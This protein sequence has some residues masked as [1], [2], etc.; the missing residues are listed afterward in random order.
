[1]TRRAGLTLREFFALGFGTM[2]GSGWLTVLGYWL[3]TAGPVGAVIAF[4]ASC[5]FVMMVALAYAELGAAYPITG[6]EVAYS[7]VAFGSPAAFTVGWM[8]VLIFIGYVCFLLV[9]VGWVFGV[10]FPGLRGPI[11]YQAFEESIYLGEMLFGLCIA[12]YLIFIN[13]RGAKV[14]ARIQHILTFGIITIGVIF[15]IT[16]LAK[17]NLSNLDPAI[18]VREEGWKYGSLLYAF[19]L[20]PPFYTGFNVISQAIGERAE[21]VS[22]RAVTMAMLVSIIAAMVFYCTIILSAASLLPREDLLSLDLPTAGVIRV[23]LEVDWFG[24]VVLFAGLI[25]LITTWNGGVFAGARALYSLAEINLVPKFFARLHPVYGTPAVCVVTLSAIG[26]VLAFGGRG[27]L[28]P[29]LNFMTFAIALAWSLTAL[30]AW[31]ARNKEPGRKRSINIRFGPLIFATG[32]IGAFIPVIGSIN[33]AL[34]D[35]S[36]RVLSGLYV[37]MLWTLCGIFN[38]WLIRKHRSLISETSRVEKLFEGSL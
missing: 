17:G 14:A 5:L 35:P 29:I 34:H 13:T 3:S 37:F 24:D 6:G 18:V 16:A 15:A 8:L 23:V 11:L 2:I 4:T 27:F 9:S 31:R 7:Q 33:D 12:S 26:I 19:A 1:M 30:A 25:A 38:W 20:V 10:I 36:S 22:A 28:I 21:H 32:A